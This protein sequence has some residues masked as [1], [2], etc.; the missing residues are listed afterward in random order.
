MKKA[1]CLI[2]LISQ[3]IF[4]EAKADFYFNK[5]GIKEGLSQINILSI[6]QD[7]IGAMWFGSTEG[8][9]RYNGEEVEIFRPSGDSTGLTANAI[10]AICGNKK[11]GIYILAGGDL[12]LYDI[13]KEKFECLKKDSV[14][15]IYYHEGVLF[16]ALSNKLFAYREDTK[17]IENIVEVSKIERINAICMS[18]QGDLYLG[19]IG[20]LLCM[21]MKTTEDKKY[22]LP[23]KIVN[24]IHI[25]AQNKLWVG[26]DFKGLYTLKNGFLED[27]YTHMP[28]KKSISNNQIRSIIDDDQGNIWIGTFLG[29][30]KFD[31]SRQEW[32]VFTAID[33]IPYSLSHSSIFALHKDGQGSVWIG[34]YL[35]GV[36]Y[37]NPN[38][39]VFKYY[40]SSTNNHDYLSFPFVGKMAEDEHNN[41][42]ICTEGGALNCLN[43][44]SRKLSR[45]LQEPNPLHLLTQNNQKCIWYRKEKD[46]LYIGLYNGGIS[47]FDV[48]KKTAR[49][50]VSHPEDAYGLASNNISKIQYHEG[51]LFFLTNKGL[52]KMNLETEIFCKLTDSED[53][54]K[55]LAGQA[56]STFLIDSNN[57]LWLPMHGKL[58]CLDLNTNDIKEYV[59]Q[60]D[61]PRSIGKFMSLSMFEDKAGN[62]FFATIGSGLFKYEA[63][64]DD[65]VRFTKESNGLASN[66]CY[67]VSSAPS[68]LLILLHSRG[69]S[70]FDPQHP[71]EKQFRSSSHLPLTGFGNGCAIY[72]TKEN[73]IFIGGLNGLISFREDDIAKLP[74]HFKPYFDKLFVNNKRVLPDDAR[75]IL[76]QSLNFCKHIKL[77]H[78]Q[79]DIEIEFA[80]AN[81]LSQIKNEYEYMLEG[82]DQDWKTNDNNFIS[83][84]NLN[85]G[86]YRLLLKPANQNYMA[87]DFPQLAITVSPPFYASKIAIYFY[88]LI[89]ILLCIL[90][91]RFLNWR[92]KLQSIVEFE[93]K[94]RERIEEINMLKLRFFTNIS[95]EFRTPLTL[96]IGL[97]ETAL[98]A[99]KTGVYSNKLQKIYKNALYLKGLIS[100]LLDFRKLEQGFYKLKV[101]EVE[102]VDYVRQI[103]SSFNEYAVQK[104]IHYP[105]ESSDEKITVWVDPTQFSKVI[106]NLISNAFKYTEAEGEIKVSISKKEQKIVICIQDNGIGIPNESIQKIF[107]RFYQVEHQAIK[108]GMG[109]GIGL[110]L[111]K[112]VVN[113][114][115][116]T[117]EVES[118]IEIGSN[119]IIT[120]LLGNSHFTEEE[121]QSPHRRVSDF[122]FDK[123]PILQELEPSKEYK[124]K[125][126]LRN[127][128]K[129]SILLVEDNQ[130]ILDLLVEIFSP[131]YNILIAYNGE[132]GL[133]M[134]Y[135]HQPDLVLSDV[136]M[137][138]M[139]GKEMCSAIKNDVNISHIPVILLTAQASI[140]QTIEGYMFGADDYITKPFNAALLLS[141]CNNLIYNRNLLYSRIT[142]QPEAIIN[143]KEMSQHELIFI[144]KVKQII[145]ENFDSPDFDMNKLAEILGVGRNKLYSQVKALTDLTPNELTLSLKLNEAAQLLKNQKHLN[146][147]EIATKFG[148]SSTK[149]FSKCFKAFYGITPQLWRKENL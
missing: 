127:F 28:G 87:E 120:L 133:E 22:F 101:E 49:R 94:E 48:Q 60:S 144:D 25:D 106:S 24:C 134:C 56:G 66:Y 138:I 140:D 109:T 73:E 1:F 79:N 145:K 19:G 103:Y 40:G 14:S 50:I 85:S 4:A 64:T 112:E 53:A 135:N 97:L 36:N 61:N 70:F 136:M 93:R 142:K 128:D 146:V 91:V 84:T 17:T 81:Y 57:R 20:G 18:A 100:D 105:F 126:I 137:P 43:L 98:H 34:T 35:G 72:T 83:Y 33:D 59:Y 77:R 99:D 122:V 41:L 15:A 65:F 21:D 55:L 69:F 2:F 110:A 82:F 45:Y 74:Q 42:W 13:K 113:Q 71:N 16:F 115:K 131:S 26:T 124:T 119:F 92:S 7:E 8:L 107:T 58:I 123:K 76:P 39:D 88:I 96:M 63:Q 129:S 117:L 9:N 68:G 67:Y 80:S 121:K 116:A 5:I 147:S 54:N 114:H 111:A 75:G 149:Y 52:T 148:F 108:Y 78:D 51:H 37:F 44:G 62:I 10:Y 23:G 90:G 12:T 29:L 118:S 132:E 38:L 95:H 125:N 11:G 30:N 86:K 47:I 141:R 143:H 27:H 104:E 130:E 139:S 31:P 32:E 6:Y 46:L 89:S 102:L 3:I